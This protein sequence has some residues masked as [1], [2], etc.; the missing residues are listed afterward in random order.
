MKLKKLQNPFTTTTY[1]GDEYFCDRKIE[2]KNLLDN[3][4]NGISTTIVAL[5]RIGK[6]GLILHVLEKLPA[7]YKGVYLDILETENLNQFLNNLATAILKAVPEKSN[8]GKK[9]TGFFRSL[10]PV[11]SFDAL[12]GVPK[13]SF[14]LSTNEAELN[15]NSVLQFLEKQDFKVLICIDEFQQIVK[16]PEK[17]YRCLASCTNTAAKKCK[18]YLLR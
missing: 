15:I 11:I 1:F 13:A 10:R 5:R 7:H 4:T 3:I 16:Y 6:T 9:F 14:D 17:K 2:T 12:T 8:P 18:L